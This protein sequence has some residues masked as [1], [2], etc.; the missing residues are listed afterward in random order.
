MA[1]NLIMRGQHPSVKQ[2]TEV[3]AFAEICH[4]K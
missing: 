2:E 3:Q 4:K 1:I